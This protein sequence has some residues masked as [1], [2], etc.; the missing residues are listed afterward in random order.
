MLYLVKV[1]PIARVTSGRLQTKLY[2]EYDDFIFP[3]VIFP[4]L[5]ANIT[6]APSYRIY[7]SQLMCYSRVCA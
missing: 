1:S 6:V 2:D 5:S 3:I 4:R 7:I